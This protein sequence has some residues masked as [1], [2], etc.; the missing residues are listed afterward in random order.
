MQNIWANSTEECAP[1][2][3]SVCERVINSI[4]ISFLSDPEYFR[5]HQ[6]Y[7]ILGDC[8]SKEDAV[9]AT[10]YDAEDAS[11]E[12]SDWSLCTGEEGEMKSTSLPLHLR[13]MPRP[14]LEILPPVLQNVV[15]D[16]CARQSF[17]LFARSITERTDFLAPILFPSEVGR[18]DRIPSIST[19]VARSD[20]EGTLG[21][22]GGVCCIFLVCSFLR[23]ILSIFLSIFYHSLEI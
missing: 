20:G 1:H 22:R 18:E 14:L 17:A 8:V 5:A 21:A 9:L 2:V 23:Q 3:E 7:R 10:E 16:I 13:S 19:N 6:V 11:D 4:D 15:D 12:E